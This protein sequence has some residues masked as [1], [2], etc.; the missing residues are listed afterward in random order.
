MFFPAL[1][2][3]PAALRSS[4]VVPQSAKST[5]VVHQSCRATPLHR[6][7]R[8]TPIGYCSARSTPVVHQSARSTPVQRPSHT[9]DHIVTPTP[10]LGH[11]SKPNASPVYTSSPALKC[12]MSP[13]GFVNQTTESSS[14]SK[15]SSDYDVVSRKKVLSK[16]KLRRRGQTPVQVVGAHSPEHHFYQ[17]AE[18]LEQE[19]AASVLNR[20][21]QAFYVGSSSDENRSSGHATMSDAHSSYISSS[22][23]DEDN[24]RA[25]LEDEHKQHINHQ[26]HSQKKNSEITPLSFKANSKRSVHSRRRVGDHHLRRVHANDNLLATIIAEEGQKS[27]DV[28]Q[29]MHAMEQLKLR[30]PSVSNGYSTSTSTYSSISGTSLESEPQG[31]RRLIRHSSLETIATNITTAD[32]FVWLDSHS[33]LVELQHLPWSSHEILRVLQQGRLKNFISRISMEAVLRLSY[34]LQRPLVR[35]AREAQRFCRVFGICSKNEII[36]SI[37]VILST[38]LAD[39]CINAGHRTAAIYAVNGENHKQSKSNQAGLQLSVGKFHRWMSDVNI[40]TFVHDFAAIYLTAAIENLL[41]EIVLLCLSL[42]SETIVSIQVLDSCIANS[43]DL[44]GIL[45]PN[46]HLNAGRTANGALILPL[47]H[48]NETSSDYSSVSSTQAT[49]MSTTSIQENIP[50]I[51]KNLLTTCVGSIQELG[52]F[53]DAVNQIVQYKTRFQSATN[54]AVGLCNGMNG[55][56]NSPCSSSGTIW[57]QAALSSLYY[58]MRCVQMEHNEHEQHSTRNAS[59]ELVYERPYLVLPPLTEWVR[60]ASAHAEYRRSSVIDKDDVMQAARLLL[61]GVDCPYRQINYFTDDWLYTRKEYSKNDCSKKLKIDLAFKMLLCGRTDLVP[62]A[63]SLLPP[64]SGVNTMNE[65]G[66][67][68]LMLAC[69]QGDEAM[70]HILLNAGAD[71]DLETLPAPTKSCP[72]ICPEIQ[73]WTALTFATIHQHISIVK[74]LLEKGANVEGGAKVNEE[75]ATETPLQLASASGNLELV[76]LL[77][78]YGAHPFLSTITTDCMSVP[79]KG[80]CSAIAVAAGHGQRVI[81]RTLLAHPLATV[82]KDVLS[83]EEILAEGQAT[84]RSVNRIQVVPVNQANA[85]ITTVTEDGNKV[86]HLTKHQLRALQEAIYHSVENGHL[87]ITLDLRNFGVPWTLYCWMQTLSTAHEMKLDAITDQ[88]L[89]DFLHL[90]PDDCSAQFVDECLPLLFSIFRHCKNEGTSLLLADIFYTCYGQEMIKAINNV[91]LPGGTRIDPKYVNNPEMSDVMFMVETKLLYSHKIILVNASSKFKQLLTSKPTEPSSG[92]QP[93]IHQINDIRYDIFLLILKF[94]YNG[95]FDEDEVNEKDLFELLAGANHYELPGLLGYCEF[96]L[97][98]V[99]DLEN[100]VSI[101]IHANVYNAINLQEY[102]QGFILQHLV[103]LLTYDETVRKLLFAKSLR[104]HDVLTGLLLTLQSRVKERSLRSNVSIPGQPRN[105]QFLSQRK[106][107]FFYGAEKDTKVTL[108][109]KIVK[110][111]ALPLRT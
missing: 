27:S 101:Y 66:L 80:C 69:I 63:L 108:I 1:N 55:T 92:T 110:F 87:E 49:A 37:K 29:I 59:Q 8:S 107:Q 9:Y 21:R 77:L 106:N 20:Q 75:R 68:P 81:L 18:S 104:N 41:E 96:R 38:N 94:L 24:L 86:I 36:S 73:Y 12:P 34:L 85:C 65:Q 109:S 90:W 31:F 22:P 99:V 95:G 32:E 56:R 35:I 6:S 33:R 52:Q 44:W 23:T 47:L 46:A 50:H 91:N 48:S 54:S 79:S 93:P 71:I 26:Y 76:K 74:L 40:G 98:K 4:P 62:C 7:A 51:E 84:I 2:G 19:R 39:T 16:W 5:P 83:L 13:T 15:S 58:F 89:Q 57:E 82:N 67:T 88:L 53:R 14:L 64:T 105:K 42:N 97:S 30:V 78:S 61:P 17:T 25:L 10:F 43:P 45:Q 72:N 102:C 60:V 3:V 100:V 70:V 103:A 111:L 11:R 28:Q